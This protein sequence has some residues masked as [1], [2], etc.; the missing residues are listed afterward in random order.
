MATDQDARRPSRG[1]RRYYPDLKV[2]VIRRDV[3]DPEAWRRR[4]EILA[5][6]LYE[7]D[8]PCDGTG[9]GS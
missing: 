1:R 4:V 9:A 8:T 5:D 2:T 6:L 3:D 7:P